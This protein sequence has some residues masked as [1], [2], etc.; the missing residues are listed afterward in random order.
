[1]KR[2]LVLCTALLLTLAIG[3]G[4]ARSST[5]GR[6][7][8]A[9]RSSHARARAAA[10]T[11]LYGVTIDQI[12]HL[13]PLI[14]SL[15]ALPERPTT[16]VYF[17]V[18][19]AASYYAQALQQLDPVTGVMGEL[20][21][22][23]DEKAIS[24]GA[25]Q[26][27]TESYLSALGTRVSIWE[28]GNEVNGNWTGSYPT[29]AEKLTEAYDDVAAAGGQT[30]LTLYANDFGPD[31][32]GDGEAELTPLQFSQQYVPSQVADG[33]NYVLLSYYP[34]QCGG[35]EPSSEE[36]VPYLE[37]LHAVYPN[38]LL[39]IGE[40]GLPKRVKKSS[41]AQAEEIM[42]WAYS[43]KPGLSY[44]V[45]GYFWWYAAEDALKP[46]APLR[47]ALQAAFGDESAALAGAPAALAPSS[48]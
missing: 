21:D 39:G 45:G 46:K 8:I 34:T 48:P 29:V 15:A 11:P 6:S 47:A 32:C 22:S 1:V 25:F 33:L 27:R 26:E 19:E 38:A 7:R 42:Q 9:G 17:G 3:V 37:R 4:P 5:A 12:T 10:V 43:L 35:S 23:S 28:V 31:H 13:Q 36:L 24:V 2:R 40:V 41:R 44:Y 18:H 14:S 30:A 16:R 20:L